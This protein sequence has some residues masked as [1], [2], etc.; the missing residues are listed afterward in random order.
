MTPQEERKMWDLQQKVRLLESHVVRISKIIF[1]LVNTE[2]DQLD[3]KWIIGKEAE[4]A[5]NDELIIGMVEKAV[6][7]YYDIT[8]ETLKLKT[9]KREIVQKRQMAM[10][11][12]KQ[13]TNLSLIY[14]GNYF[15]KKDH[16][17]VLHAVKTVNNL[18]D[19]KYD[20][21]E[22]YNAVIKSVNQKIFAKKKNILK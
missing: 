11:I 16:A 21:N 9:R 17:T 22:D 7:E 19:T 1:P 18:C 10:V 4:P 5:I 2:V 8:T 13:L 14:I 12:T 6:C 15:G 20:Y 3:L